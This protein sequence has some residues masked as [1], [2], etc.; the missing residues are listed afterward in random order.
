MFAGL[1]VLKP[2]G[3]FGRETLA[4]EPTFDFFL[5][6]VAVLAGCRNAD[7]ARNH[8]LPCGA[9]VSVLEYT[10]KRTENKADRTR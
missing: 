9:C 2:C 7:V 10:L 3:I 4:F 5:L 8:D 6:A 1:F